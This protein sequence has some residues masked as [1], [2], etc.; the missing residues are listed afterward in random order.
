MAI[1]VKSTKKF[2]IFT[3]FEMEQANIMESE[4]AEFNKELEMK[5]A[6]EEAE[7]ERSLQILKERR[8]ELMEQRKEKMLNE[9]S[10]TTTETE[11]EQLLRQYNE[12]AKRLESKAQADLIRQEADL[13]E[14]IRKKKEKMKKAKDKELQEQQSKRLQEQEDREL[15]ERQKMAEQEKTRLQE[16]VTAQDSILSPDG[17]YDNPLEE[18]VQRLE[19][20]EEMLP[21]D[22]MMGTMPLTEEQL[23]SLL[24]ST[25]IYQKLEQIRELLQSAPL[26]AANS[27][28][29]GPQK[30]VPSE[31]GFAYI[32]SQDAGWLYDTEFHPVDLNSIPVRAFVVYKFGV[33][34]IDLLCRNRK[35]PSVHLLLADKI[36]P[37]KDL[38]RN[39]YRN[40]FRFE[41]HNRILYIRLCRLDN[42]GEFVVVLVHTLAH[43]KTDTLA[44]DMDPLFIKEFYRSL[45]ICCSDF[46]FS[47]HNSESALAATSDEPL[48]NVLEEIFERV[49]TVSEKSDALDDIID[50][51]ILMDTTSDGNDFS[52]ENIMTRL[53]EYQDFM[54][55]S[56]LKDY[57][58]EVEE[59][60]AAPDHATADYV[61]RRLM[62]L[63]EKNESSRR[64][65][66]M[67]R[68]ATKWMSVLHKSPL[69]PTSALSRSLPR[70]SSLLRRKS[71]SVTGND[72]PDMYKQML[73]V[74]NYIATST[75]TIC[76][77][78]YFYVAMYLCLQV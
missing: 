28:A 25:P 2:T 35:Y 15:Q 61:D 70:S 42:V 14:K 31:P 11:R 4:L 72:K 50:T 48:L 63:H 7:A 18:E 21:E 55:L 46:F 64:A 51:R 73:Q 68:V 20:E 10:V 45:S 34:I 6:Q 23:S 47:R 37:N 1:Y 43:I 22:Y 77:S 75:R 71:S 53:D 36:P 62:E 29:A 57:L 74:N 3:E 38:V 32:D 54:Q 40:S 56:K 26:A 30:V 12:D 24:M 13:K 52:H 27:A 58:G 60:I 44:D 19:D 9:I 59:N 41:S 78:L 5:S 66:S 76:V 8:M 16:T 69:R 67:H 65:G 17:D 49:H 33:F 39:A